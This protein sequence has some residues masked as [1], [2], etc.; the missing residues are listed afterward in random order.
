MHRE[1]IIHRMKQAG[2]IHLDEEYV[3]LEDGSIYSQIHAF[4][5]EI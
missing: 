1:L 2:F 3:S 4:K 5:I